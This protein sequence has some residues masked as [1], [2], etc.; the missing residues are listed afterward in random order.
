MRN[1][2]FCLAALAL[3]TGLS[4]LQARPRTPERIL[5]VFAHPDD[6]LLTAGWLALA[7]EAGHEIR[8]IYVTSG[9]AGQDRSGRG[10]SGDSLARVREIETRRANRYLGIEREPRFLRF[11][12][13]RVGLKVPQV[14]E[15][16]AAMIEKFRPTRLLT[17]GPDGITGHRDHIAVNVATRLAKLRVGSKAV[18]TELVFD[19]DR[20][21]A[22]G[23]DWG[24][25][26]V[27][28]RSIDATLDL[29]KLGLQR[30]RLFEIH[31]T[32]FTRAQIEAY[33][34]QTEA[35]DKEEHFVTGSPLAGLPWK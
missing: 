4:S 25:H 13:G 10:L 21:D 28:S 16:L 27:H 32:Q 17:L 18:V 3:A 6:E 14:A 19:K 22:F 35:R 30:K 20:A 26:W 24:M 2:S 9:D 7:A 23:K 33:E 34:A 15:D 8:A 1:L 31:R 29:K 11:E 12:D 5:A